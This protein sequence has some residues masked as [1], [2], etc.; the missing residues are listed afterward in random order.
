MERT[1]LYKSAHQKPSTLKPGTI[2]LTNNIIRA[3]SMSKKRPR[4]SIVTGSVKIMSIGFKN[5]LIRPKTIATMIATPKLLTLTPGM[6]Y[7]LINTARAVTRML[8]IRVIYI[9]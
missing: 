6:R 1:I 8:I 5:T 7:A 2:A 9:P 4:V 3:L